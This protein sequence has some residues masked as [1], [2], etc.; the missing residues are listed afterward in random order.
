MTLKFMEGSLF[1]ILDILF[2]FSGSAEQELDCRCRSLLTIITL[3]D[4]GHHL[5]LLKTAVP[6]LFA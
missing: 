2:I 1:Y 4:H 3:Q 5:E 6:H